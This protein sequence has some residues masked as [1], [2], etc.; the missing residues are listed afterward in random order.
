MYRFKLVYNVFLSVVCRHDGASMFDNGL[1][2]RYNGGPG[3][4]HG[5]DQGEAGAGETFP[6]GGRYQDAAR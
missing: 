3:L 4:H 5:K 2:G 6:R 1:R